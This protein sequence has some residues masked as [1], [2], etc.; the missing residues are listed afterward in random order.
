MLSLPPGCVI[1]KATLTDCVN[2]DEEVKEELRRKNAPVYAGTTD[3]SK[4]DGYGFKLEII[5][6]IEPICMNNVSKLS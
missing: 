3:N 6:K 1:A 4:F 5:K 2:V